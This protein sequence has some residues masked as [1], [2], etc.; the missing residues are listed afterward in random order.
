M[1]FLFSVVILRPILEQIVS[2]CCSPTGI[3]LVLLL[4]NSINFL[5]CKHIFFI[6]Q[7]EPDVVCLPKNFCN[8][9]FENYDNRIKPRLHAFMY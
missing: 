3:S 2:H 1:I 7:H 5:Y 8:S 9:S 4:T 6:F